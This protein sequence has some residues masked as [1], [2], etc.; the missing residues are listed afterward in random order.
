MTANAHKYDVQY[1][2]R[3]RWGCFS[4]LFS[5]LR[6]NTT[7]IS[8]KKLELTSLFCVIT[9]SG[10]TS[11]FIA[12]S[13][14]TTRGE[15]QNIEICIPSTMERHPTTKKLLWIYSFSHAWAMIHMLSEGFLLTIYSCST[16]FILIHK[17]LIFSAQVLFEPQLG[18]P[19][20]LTRLTKSVSRGIW[21]RKYDAA[22][23]ILV[24]KCMGSSAVSL[25]LCLLG[26][27]RFF[28]R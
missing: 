7:R 14:S 4:I 11:L 17:S 22:K 1:C 23:R 8:L 2:L 27:M 19:K 9:H 25:T 10:P 26:V 24:I 5:T 6:H 15:C 21:L 28:T 12:K 16:L 13:T 20:D 18:L 3:W